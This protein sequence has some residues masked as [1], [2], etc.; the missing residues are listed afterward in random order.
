VAWR[1][2]AVQRLL[3]QPLA[4]CTAAADAA[5]ARARQVIKREGVRA[6]WRG[7]G[8]TIVHRLP[9]SAVNFWA[10]ERF[11]EMWLHRYP[12]G[13]S[14]GARAPARAGSGRSDMLRRLAAGGAAG[15][16]ACTLVRARPALLA[17]LLRPRP[18]RF[19]PPAGSAASLCAGGNCPPGFRP[20][21]QVSKEDHN[22]RTTTGFK[23]RGLRQAYPL[24]LV[25]TRLAAQTGARY[26]HS[27]AHALRTIVR[28][29]GARG[30]YSGLGATLLQA[31][32]PGGALKRVPPGSG[33]LPAQARSH[34]SGGRRVRRVR[35][36]QAQRGLSEA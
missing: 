28:E 1:L 5:R 24:D 23:A 33:A 2:A 29:E 11:T 31:R 8:V 13:G 15:L 14:G 30:L 21:L 36:Q 7:N 10:Y 27:I 9:Y 3:V 20:Q 16:C 12:A 4:P 25:R 19:M 35:S 22:R 17:A 18:C 6:L 34:R 26:Y 32:A